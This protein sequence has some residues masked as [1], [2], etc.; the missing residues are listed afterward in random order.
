MRQVALR[1]LMWLALTSVVCADQPNILFIVSDD[2]GWGDYSF[3]GHPAIETP[4]LDRL[5][6]ESLTFTRGYVPDSLCRPSLATILS[7]MYPHQHGIV[8]ND[9]P[10]PS[11]PRTGKKVPSTDP[12]YRAIREEYIEHID[13]VPTLPKLLRSQGYASLQTGKWWE[14]NFARGG[15]T[16]GMTHGDMMREGRHGDEGLK[17]GREGL[18]EVDRFIEGSVKESKP[19]FVW[20]API[21]PH[22]PHNPPS[23][24]L[25]K[26]QG[27][28]DSLPLAKYWAMCEWFD[29]TVGEVRELLLKHGVERNTLICY[30][31]DNGWINDREASRYAPRS[32]RSPNEGGVRTPILVHWAG[33][34][35]PHRNEVNLASSLD[36]VPTV[37]AAL[38]IPKDEKL[39]GINLLDA[40][41]VQERTALFGEIFEHDVVSINEPAQSLRYRWMID[42]TWKLILPTSRVPEEKP[43]LYDLANDPNEM[44]DLAEREPARL[45]RMSAAID[46]NWDPAVN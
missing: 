2:Q 40:K 7:G 38:Q 6:S 15:F 30:V 19:F 4:H 3:M 27:R 31:A 11:E 46:R 25:T 33:R 14:G 9:P 23:R 20:Y 29:E 10:L 42:E 32:K 24:L 45:R 37:L 41:A 12:R 8:G 43:M 36:L 18:A 35:V 17:I 34:I 39:P 13:R 28:T 1:G 22:T 16:H 5:A 44:V 26:Y 21:L